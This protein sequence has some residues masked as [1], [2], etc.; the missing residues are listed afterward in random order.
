VSEARD[1]LEQWL[2]RFHDGERD[3][4]Q[5]CAEHAEQRAELERLWS[6]LVEAGVVDPSS[7]PPPSTGSSALHEMSSG[8]QPPAFLGESGVPLEGSRF[9]H[10][11]IL[12]EL[13]RG[14]QGTVFL[15]EDV[16]IGRQVALKVLPLWRLHREEHKQ[17]FAREAELA[18]RLEHPGLCAVYERGRHGDVAFLAMQFVEGE[19]LAERIAEQRQAKES[20]QQPGRALRLP[21]LGTPSN[22]TEAVR[23]LLQLF[24]TLAGA[25]HAAHEARLIHRD[26]K[27]GNIIVGRDGSPVLLD[28]GLAKDVEEET[29][30]LTGDLVGTP[31]YMS[32]EQLVAQRIELDRRSDVYSLGATLF[33][34]LTLRRP[35]EAATREELYQQILA[36]TAPD[37]RKLNPDLSRDLAVVIATTLEKDR[38]QRYQSAD[39]LAQDLRRIRL[40][41]AILARPAGPRRRLANWAKR[42]PA[43][44]ISLSSIFVILVTALAI[45]LASRERMLQA[46]ASLERLSLAP[47]LET[48]QRQ[49][50]KLLE[51]D[52]PSARHSDTRLAALRDWMSRYGQVFPA[53]IPDLQRRI[54]ELRSRAL[55]ESEESLARHRQRHPA[56]DTL[57]RKR[58]ELDGYRRGYESAKQREPERDLEF[59]RAAIREQERE[60]AAL[61]RTIST[62]RPWRMPTPEEQV[63]HDA[64]VRLVAELKIFGGAH[65]PLR[66]IV[67]ELELLREIRERSPQLQERWQAAQARIAAHSA[68]AGF[69]LREQFGLVPLGPDKG[70]TLEEFALLGSGEVPSRDERGELVLEADSALIL[71]LVPGGEYSFGARMR[72]PLRSERRING[73]ELAPFFVGKH[74]LTQ[75]QWERLGGRRFESDFSFASLVQLAQR[76]PLQPI[77]GVPW[78]AARSLLRTHGLDLPTEVQWEYAARGGREARL[79]AHL[80]SPGKA[81]ANLR[82]RNFMTGRSTRTSF[83]DGYMLSA[84]IGSF[85]P[86]DFGLHE[87]IGNV[88]EWCREPGFP[89][90][91]D[92]FARDPGDAYHH[93]PL[94]DSYA[95][96]GGSYESAPRQIYIGARR[97]RAGGGQWPMVG[98]RPVRACE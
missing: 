82:D 21:E 97:A 80:Q 16:K 8:S 22:E 27:P 24:E 41:Q 36:S 28:F 31:A 11:Q 71:V 29:L 50:R 58:R 40:K 6:R 98:I 83:D 91:L 92:Y 73:I 15:A 14:A 44:A 23:Q 20:A 89:G 87:V 53:A 56:Q 35:F 93:A 52:D 19:T 42:N 77:S 47:E 76:S 61:T 54:R 13:G 57:V 74:E 59:M 90:P 75:R 85:P 4:E 96:R 34:A 17:R 10:Y 2:L 66:R 48:A 55:P 67:R 46:R 84:P 5:F 86:N 43:I 39:D 30:T 18:S 25:L 94:G 64:L 9:G 69:Q 95:V 26:I 32:P 79:P 49:A 81:V 45:T 60:I 12:R 70:S 33:E 65:G 62:A 63:T 3:F 68:F 7:E 1:L 72:R 51:L 88:S 38:R 78:G 37:I